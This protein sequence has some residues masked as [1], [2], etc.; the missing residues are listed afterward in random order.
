M[1][2]ENVCKD[3]LRLDVVTPLV[4]SQFSPSC[5]CDIHQT[6]E[7]RKENWP[8]VFYPLI[9]HDFDTIPSFLFWEWGPGGRKASRDPA[10]VAPGKQ[11]QRAGVVLVDGRSRLPSFRAAGERR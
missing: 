5:C 6:E 3:F 4:S 1:T 8:E 11:E 9:F 2:W 10:K 7:M